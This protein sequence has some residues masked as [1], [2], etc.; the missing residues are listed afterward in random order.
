MPFDDP[1]VGDT[2]AVDATPDELFAQRLPDRLGA[3]A[4]DF[5][6]PGP[7]LDQRSLVRGKRMRRTRRLQII[8][9]TAAMAAVVAM[10]GGMLLHRG[11]SLPVGA[12]ATPSPSQSAHTVPV[13]VAGPTVGPPVSAAD[14][15]ATLERTL[16]PGGS[17]SKSFLGDGTG[18]AGGAPSAAIVYSTPHGSSEIDVTISRDTPGFPVDSED[19]GGCIGIEERPYDVCTTTIEPDGSVLHS[20]T[21]FTHPDSDTGQKRWYADLMRPDGVQLFVEEF[22]ASAGSADPLLSLNQLAAVVQ[23]PV[24]AKAVAATPTPPAE[25]LLPVQPGTLPA[26]QMAHIFQS[27]LPAGGTVGNANGQD[28]FAEVVF[29]DGH[30]KAMIQVNA[31]PKA[32]DTAALFTCAQT[33]TYCRISTLP[34]GTRV[35]AVQTPNEKGGRASV[36]RVDTL[37]PDGYRVVALECNSY[38]EATPPTRPQPPL[39]FAQLQALATSPL[40]GH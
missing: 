32:V 8:G 1:A 12:A 30:G 39:T 26:S 14:M 10:V 18:S 17:Y 31:Q 20:T 22:G 2:A 24:W 36:W 27:L 40:W 25:A 23:S 7:H 28:G 13:P 35:M 37:R 15:L 4:E 29:D 16:P 6:P 3:A 19:K 21:S 34:D 9:S 33:T 38:S 5:P 11:P